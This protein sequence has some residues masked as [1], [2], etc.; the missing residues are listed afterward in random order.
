MQVVRNIAPAFE[1]PS[2]SHSCL[3]VQVLVLWHVHQAANNTILAD[4][5]SVKAATMC[6]LQLWPP[7]APFR[8]RNSEHQIKECPGRLRGV[9][10]WGVFLR[11]H[12]AR[13]RYQGMQETVLYCIWQFRWSEA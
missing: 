11:H 2:L 8:D 13:P 12:V 1:K 10:M 4:Q 5:V 9:K 6:R 3:I 7:F